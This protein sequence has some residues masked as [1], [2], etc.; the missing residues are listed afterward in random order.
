MSGACFVCMPLCVSL[1]SQT[2][3]MLVSRQL[4]WTI[5]CQDEWIINSVVV[6]LN[7]APLNNHYYIAS[8]SAF[9]HYS[10]HALLLERRKLVGTNLGVGE[11]GCGVL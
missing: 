6:D 11:H 9:P 5:S 8:R 10:M 1:Y 2:V 4:E 7:P 3:G